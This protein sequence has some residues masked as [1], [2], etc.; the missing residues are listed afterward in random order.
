MARIV[1]ITG[2]RSTGHRAAADLAEAF[3]A[4]LRPFANADAHFY[5]GGAAGI[6][7][8]ALNW[9]A[10]H[11][12]AAVTVVVPCTVA[13]QP[14][15]AAAAINRCGH[16]GRLTAV[17]E[18]RA[19]EL[20]FPAYHM[21]NRWMVDR[22]ELVIGFPHGDKPASGTWYT[23]NYAAEQVKPRLIVPV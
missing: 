16:Q 20:G 17:V 6:D 9:L 19:S 15:V 1:T 7:T 2:T 8:L 21:R 23:L 22:S 18:L 3:D 14:D 10:E 11:T 13:D 12:S 4:Y 5:V